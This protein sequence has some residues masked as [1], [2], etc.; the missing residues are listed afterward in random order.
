[1]IETATAYIILHQE[2]N[3]SLPVISQYG[4]SDNAI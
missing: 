2:D 4:N 1:M 3:L